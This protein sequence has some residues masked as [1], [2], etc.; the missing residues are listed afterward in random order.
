MPQ[1][2]AR[3]S[4]TRMRRLWE[5][6][7]H[8]HGQ[9]WNASAFAK[10]FEVSSPTVRHYVDLLTDML[11]VRQLPPVYAN[12]KKRLVKSSK[13]YIRDSGLL[14]TLLRIPDEESL[15]G[16]PIL[17]SSFEGFA[18]ENVIQSAPDDAD[19]GFYRTHAGAEIDL[20]LTLDQGERWAI[21]VKYTSVPRVSARFEQAMA[22]VGATR[23]YVITAG[24]QRY[25]V[26]ENIEVI[27]LLQIM[28]LMDA[29]G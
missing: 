13:V 5:M 7:A 12:L 20:V 9:V 4:S 19:A 28:E 8:V 23:G 17:G 1:L 26:S 15:H 3:V 27:P 29:K 22:D 16:H 2:G 11:V 10:S 25:P 24:N 18:L 6:L 21:E 14:H